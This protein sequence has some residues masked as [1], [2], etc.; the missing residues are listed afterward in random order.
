MIPIVELTVDEIEIQLGI[1]L[2][3]I[4]E[5]IED[6]SI[7]RRNTTIGKNGNLFLGLLLFT[8]F[9]IDRLFLDLLFHEAVAKLFVDLITIAITNILT[10]FLESLIEK[11]IGSRQR[12]IT[13]GEDFVAIEDRSDAERTNA[14]GRSIELDDLPR[15]DTN[16]DLLIRI[17]QFTGIGAA[18]L[19][20][21]AD[22]IFDVLL[23]G[24]MAVHYLGNLKG[25]LAG[26]NR[27]RNAERDTSARKNLRRILLNEEL[28]PI[29]NRL[30]CVCNC[31]GREFHCALPFLKIS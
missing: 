10:V 8:G 4:I 15:R 25:C 18:V 23:H 28:R 31:L 3:I 26:H 16:K 14:N 27:G 6:A 9:R 5:F 11:L 13:L 17:R 30:C 29:K 24:F 19:Q 1:L 21:T 7:D 22:R 20:L 12:R 2:P